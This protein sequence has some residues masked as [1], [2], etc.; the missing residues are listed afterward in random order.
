MAVLFPRLRDWKNKVLRSGR[1][2][3]RSAYFC[4]R[5]SDKGIGAD[6]QLKPTG[7]T[8]AQAAFFGPKKTKRWLIHPETI[9]ESALPKSIEQGDVAAFTPWQKFRRAPA[10]VYS[11]PN[12]FYHGERG[13]VID[14]RGNVIADLLDVPSDVLRERK[15]DKLFRTKTEPHLGNG[16]ALVI[17]SSR[18]YFHWLIKMLPRVALAQ[19]AGLADCETLLVNQPT[20]VQAEGYTAAGFS[21]ETLRVVKSR[22]YWCCENLYVTSIPHDV[23][24]WSVE[25]LRKTF[26]PS[27]ISS[28][29][30]AKN[31][32]LRRGHTTTRRVENEDEVCAHLHKRG[33]ASFDLSQ[34]TFRDQIQIV[35]NADMIIAPHGAA[36]ANL[37]FAS[38]GVRVL[39]IFASEENQKC[40]WLL[41][42]HRQATYHYLMA[43]PIRRSD[44]PNEFD[45]FIPVEKLDRALD[46]LLADSSR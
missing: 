27:L 32:Y 46:F 1:E 18:N 4:A 22:H 10:Y 41:A 29:D 2:R 3:K 35:A 14:H 38:T 31:I 23:P 44:K 26:P 37:A 34:H 43:N 17:S 15:L 5:L 13:A 8:S 24:S 42:Q 39:E 33:V 21:D 19:A 12:A 16:D 28:K 36:L 11:F 20:A 9:A 40:Y 7:L 45:M 30:R 6:L 25:F